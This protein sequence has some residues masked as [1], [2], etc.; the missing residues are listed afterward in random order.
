MNESQEKE[1]GSLIKSEMT[2]D[3][4][5]MWHRLLSM[6]KYVSKNKDA[7]KDEQELKGI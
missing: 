1:K 2:L 5:I 7:G 6:L 4:R 3:R